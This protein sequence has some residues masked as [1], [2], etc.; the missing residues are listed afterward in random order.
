MIKGGY[1]ESSI[2]GVTLK[3]IVLNKEIQGLRGIRYVA[4]EYNKENK[5][6]SIEIEIDHIYSDYYSHIVK[7]VPY[8]ANKSLS[9]WEQ[10]VERMVVLYLA[11]LKGEHDAMG[12]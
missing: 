2:N 8:I 6:V 11:A 5:T 1:I 4:F 10:E 9:D 7:T 3:D 12:D